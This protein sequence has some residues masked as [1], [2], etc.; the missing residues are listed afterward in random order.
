MKKIIQTLIVVPLSLL[1]ISCISNGMIKIPQKKIS[2]VFGDQEEYAFYLDG[3]KYNYVEER[4]YI[5]F[6]PIIGERPPERTLRLQ[7][8]LVNRETGKKINPRENTYVLTKQ[9]LVNIDILKL[10]DIRMGRYRK[11][12]KGFYYIF[13]HPA[14]QNITDC[15]IPL[16]SPRKP[17]YVPTGRNY[18]VHF[19]T[20]AEIFIID[21]VQV[22]S[23][24]PTD[25]IKQ[26]KP[27]D[28]S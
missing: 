1:L 16:W 3:T 5:K 8:F 9:G 10:D 28:C 26:S 27:F 21:R 17:D 14:N 24:E 19:D 12:L 6:V 15:K 25:E 2:R 4:D 11:D 23:Y 20:Q 7:F 13:R 22:H 18:I